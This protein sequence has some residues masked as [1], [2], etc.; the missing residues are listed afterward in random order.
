MQHRNLEHDIYKQVAR[1]MNLYYQ[2]TPWHF[3][4]AGVHTTSQYY[5]SLYKTINPDAGF[6]DLVVLQRSH[7]NFGEYAALFV[8]IKEAGVTIKKRDGSLVADP[9]IRDQA[10]WI[11]Q[12]NAKGYYACFATGWP[13]VQEVLDSYLRG[14]AS[15]PMEF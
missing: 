12:L 5:R 14:E 8:E 6:P 10:T 4:P 2:G 15:I 3:D 7:P 11:Q 1:H 9:H 13:S